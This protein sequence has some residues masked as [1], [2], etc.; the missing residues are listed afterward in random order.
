LAFS[1]S[2]NFSAALSLIAEDVEGEG[3]DAELGINR[4]KSVAD[5]LDGL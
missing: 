1:R 2:A 4:F 3:L 5:V